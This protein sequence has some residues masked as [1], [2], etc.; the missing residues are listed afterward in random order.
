MLKIHAHH[1]QEIS[2]WKLPLGW[3]LPSFWAGR[4]ARFSTRAGACGGRAATPPAR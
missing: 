1:T 4:A 2:I 3:S